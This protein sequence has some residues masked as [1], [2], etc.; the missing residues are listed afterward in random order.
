VLP[1]EPSPPPHADS[2]AASAAL[3]SNIRYFM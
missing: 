1:T 3:V 2:I